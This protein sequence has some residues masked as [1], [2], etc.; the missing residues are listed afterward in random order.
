MPRSSTIRIIFFSPFRGR[1]LPT[2]EKPPV[3]LTNNKAP[4]RRP[5]FPMYG[6]PSAASWIGC[7][8]GSA[9]GSASPRCGGCSTS[10]RHGVARS[11]CPILLEPASRRAEIGEPIS[12]GCH[13][14]FP[15][16]RA[17]R[18][19]EPDAGLGRTPHRQELRL[20]RLS[21][22]PRLFRTGARANALHRRRRLAKSRR[23]EHP[24]AKPIHLESGAPAGR[25]IRRLSLPRGGRALPGAGGAPR[26]QGYGAEPAR[27]PARVS[28]RGVEPVLMSISV[29]SGMPKPPIYVCHP[30]DSDPRVARHFG[31]TPGKTHAFDPES[32]DPRQ[33]EFARHIVRYAER[34]AVWDTG[35]A[36]LVYIGEGG[37]PPGRYRMDMIHL[38]RSVAVRG[39]ARPVEDAYFVLEG[40]ITVGW[41]EA[42]DTVEERLGPKDAIFN[43]A[44]RVHYF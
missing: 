26:T 1:I 41:E 8:T 43:P 32:G 21:R 20:G 23:P 19:K 35:F 39:Y 13:G 17:V 12:G 24:R 30:R 29:G 36:R 11:A 9:A 10:N 27:P 22:Q 37:A 4:R 42:G 14:H 38:P 33:R 18:S 16:S 3:F 2:G 25:Q 28:Q 34:R 40:C 44:S 31:A 7:S 5:A 15:K 6:N